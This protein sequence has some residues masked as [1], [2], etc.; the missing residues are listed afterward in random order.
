[1]KVEFPLFDFEEDDL[2]MPLV[3]RPDRLLY[4]LETVDIENDK[5]PFW[6]GSAHKQTKAP[7][8]PLFGRRVSKWF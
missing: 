2:S 6:D 8:R 1:V 5:Y 3:E 4:H 7:L